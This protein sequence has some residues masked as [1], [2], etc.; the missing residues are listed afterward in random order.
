MNFQKLKGHKK[1]K[2][3]SAQKLAYT[4]NKIQYC[5]SASQGSQNKK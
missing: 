2:R 1:G 4:K 3:P 5:C